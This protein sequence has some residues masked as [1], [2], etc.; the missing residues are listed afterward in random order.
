MDGEVGSRAEIQCIAEG[1][2]TPHV[3]WLKNN[4]PLATNDPSF[5]FYTT[6]NQQILNFVALKVRRSLLSKTKKTLKISTL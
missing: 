2:P 4:N 3:T 1:Y 5:Q 6:H